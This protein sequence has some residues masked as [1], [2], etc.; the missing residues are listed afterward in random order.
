MQT[1][2]EQIRTL[3]KSNKVDKALELLK[4]LTNSKPALDIL[5][6]KLISEWKDVRRKEIIGSLNYEKGMECK[7]E[8]SN[9][10]LGVLTQLKNYIPPAEV[11]DKR[12]FISYNHNDKEI[13]NRLKEKLKAQQIDVIIDTEKMLA[14][15]DIK[16]F[17]EESIRDSEATISVI[18]NKSLLSSWVAMETINTFYH[19]KFLKEKK[20]IACYVEADFF[21][22]S[23]TDEACE[24]IEIELNDILAAKKK[25]ID[26]A[27]DTRDLDNEFT[28]YNELKNS[29]DEIVRHLRESLCIDISGNNLDQNFQKIADTIKAV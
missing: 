18:S 11:F 23:F 13:A 16:E 12:V 10:V 17:I 1:D 20:F 5:V 24:R 25:R 3:I 15:Q 26:Q 19:K 14:G 22:R 6:D 7:A 21:R 4:G 29:M 27:R 2:I 9:A 8:L 28:R